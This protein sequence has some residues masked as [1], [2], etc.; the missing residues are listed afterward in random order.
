MNRCMTDDH[1]GRKCLL[2]GIP[3]HQA[4][5]HGY[6]HAVVNAFWLVINGEVAFVMQVGFMILE[7]GSVPLNTQKRWLFVLRT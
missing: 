6:G 4:V 5:Q 3:P 2:R 7:V 1:I